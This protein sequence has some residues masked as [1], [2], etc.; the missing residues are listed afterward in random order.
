MS[1]SF[2]LR[3]IALLFLLLAALH[4]ALPIVPLELGWG[5]MFFWLLSETFPG[6]TRAA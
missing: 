4:V 3:L 5:G 6:P 2:I 1:I